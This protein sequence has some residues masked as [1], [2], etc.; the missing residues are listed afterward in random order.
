MSPSFN[1]KI[2]ELVTYVAVCFQ[3]F[4]ILSAFVHMQM[5]GTG[6]IPKGAELETVDLHGKMKQ[7]PVRMDERRCHL[8]LPQLTRQ[9]VVG[10]ADVCENFAVLRNHASLE[11]PSVSGVAQSSVKSPLFSLVKQQTSGFRL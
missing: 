6:C 4:M 3:L 8:V 7:K 2:R 5:N 10:V 1:A 9:V 11:Q